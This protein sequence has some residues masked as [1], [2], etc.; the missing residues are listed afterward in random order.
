MKST[1]I[2]FGLVALAAAIPAPAPA[3]TEI[4]KV[5]LLKLI[6]QVH[7]ANNGDQ[8]HHRRQV[9]GEVGGSVGSG[10]SGFVSGVVGS[11]TLAGC[12]GGVLPNGLGATIC[13]PPQFALPTAAP[14][15]RVFR[16]CCALFEY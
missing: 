9:G 11:S 13:F 7:C 3:I 16:R 8:L 14:K 5:R 6:S 2:T 4:A 15:V 1:F 12:I 10:L